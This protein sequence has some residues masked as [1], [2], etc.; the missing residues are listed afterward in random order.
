MQ[1][2][3]YSIRDSKA[4][5][6]G[7][8]FSQ[9]THG[10]AERTFKRLATPAPQGQE[11]TQISQYPEDYDLYYLGTFDDSTGKVNWLDTPQHM[12]KAN[13]A[14]S[15]AS[16]EAPWPTEPPVQTPPPKK[17]GFLSNLTQ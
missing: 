17:K 16:Q 7:F 4:E 14:L 1:K 15:A 8:P 13:N 11:S 2:K 6:Y 9:L 12:L 5:I 3:M 10:E